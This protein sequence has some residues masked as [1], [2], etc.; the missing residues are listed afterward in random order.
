MSLVAGLLLGTVPTDFVLAHM[1]LNIAAANGHEDAALGR[2]ALELL[3]SAADVARA[4]RL[5]WREPAGP[6]TTGTAASQPR[7]ETR[8]RLANPRS[9][10]PHDG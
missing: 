4:T 9:T 8:P 5:A 3:M 7:S 10:G 6:R 2:D 1:W